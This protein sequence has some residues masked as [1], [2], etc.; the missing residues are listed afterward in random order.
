MIAVPAILWR[1]AN[2]SEE[3]PKMAI[4]ISQVWT[5][6]KYVWQQKLK[7]NKRYPLC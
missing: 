6:T 7:G 3:D 4:P 5:V 2:R 1:V